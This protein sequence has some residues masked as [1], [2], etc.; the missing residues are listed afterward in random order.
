[1]TTAKKF[2]LEQN[3][4]LLSNI[5][6]Y[7]KCLQAKDF[8][9]FLD[10]SYAMAGYKTKTEYYEKHNLTVVFHNIKNPC[11][12]INSADGNIVLI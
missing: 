6:G 11:L 5:E 8:Q 1:M 4:A 10:N 12:F 9:V 2:H 3:A 7:D